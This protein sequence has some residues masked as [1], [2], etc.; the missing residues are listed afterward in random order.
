[1]STRS[2][3]GLELSDGSILSVYCHWDGYPEHNGEILKNHYTSVEKIKKLMSYGNLSLLGEEIGESND[4]RNPIDG[5]CL[6]YGRDRGEINTEAKQFS[7]PEEY[8]E[9]CHF[10]EYNYVYVKGVW[11]CNGHEKK[12]NFTNLPGNDVKLIE[13]T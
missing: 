5:V 2:R 9:K 6:F 12:W 7:S 13:S 10:E 11:V 8:L 4:F 1:M 3:I